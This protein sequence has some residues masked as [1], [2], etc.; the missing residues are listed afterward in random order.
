VKS[1]D[2]IIVGGGVIGLACA[3]EL[4]RRELKVLVI[5]R[6]EPGREASHAA[7]GMLAHC[8]PHTPE[9]LRP[10]ANASAKRYHELVVELQDE[11]GINI[12]LR[13]EGTIV[14]LEN[15]T[16]ACG[17]PIS[18]HALRSLEPRL[19]APSAAH[20]LPEASVDPRKL[21]EALVMALHKRQIDLSSGAAVIEVEMSGRKVIAVR[22]EKSR[23]PTRVAINCAGAWAARIAPVPFRTRPVKGQML[24]VV[25]PPH[26][27]FELSH[28]VRHQTCY[29]VPRTDGRV[30]IGS[31]V[32]EVGYD[33]H[34]DPTTIQKLHQSAANLLPELGQ[35]RILEAWSGLRPGTPDGLPML[36]E[37]SY[38]GY[39]AATGHFRDGILLAPITGHVIAK[40]VCGETPEYDL[41]PF[42]PERF[43]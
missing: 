41:L 24:S 15:E 30:V 26:G 20:F 7:A 18:D 27:H 8:D 29:L 35:G 43:L 16:P 11:T 37:T 3:L 28:V 39:L 23:Y 6:G 9:V 42:S 40:L 36:G 32:E 12:D 38:G 4:S 33:K 10:I 1:W 21:V 2:A 5:E 22:T 14:F 31:T 19:A 25:P 17:E 34:V 13:R